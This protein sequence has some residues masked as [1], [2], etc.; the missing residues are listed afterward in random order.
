M[1]VIM[2]TTLLV[3]AQVII[4]LTMIAHWMMWSCATTLLINWRMAIERWKR[5]QKAYETQDECKADELWTRFWIAVLN[6]MISQIRLRENESRR[7]MFKEILLAVATDSILFYLSSKAK[8]MDSLYWQTC[9]VMSVRLL[10]QVEDIN[11]LGTL[12]WSSN[13]R[14]ELQNWWFKPKCGALCIQPWQYHLS[15]I[16]ELE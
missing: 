2:C 4:T 14:R 10:E 11:S 15:R 12:F 5:T 7:T 6:V 8:L 13:F 1:F 9:F 16:S 3:D